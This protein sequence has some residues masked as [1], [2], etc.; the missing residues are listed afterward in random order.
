MVTWA[1]NLPWLYFSD[2][3][4][5]WACHYPDWLNLGRKPCRAGEHPSQLRFLLVAMTVQPRDFLGSWFLPL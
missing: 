4:G 1:V 2:A 5:P 3:V